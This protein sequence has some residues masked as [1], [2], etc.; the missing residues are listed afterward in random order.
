M[1]T[2]TLAND[3]HSSRAFRAGP[4]PHMNVRSARSRV[5][6][7][8]VDLAPSTWMMAG[9]RGLQHFAGIRDV[10]IIGLGRRTRP[11]R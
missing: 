11:G 5:G 2:A 6:A 4:V 7:D 10:D 3:N 8:D 9:A 1:R